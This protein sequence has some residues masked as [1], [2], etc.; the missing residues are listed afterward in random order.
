M[1]ENTFKDRRGKG[2]R[3]HTRR[4]PTTWPTDL[5]NAI[6]N[7]AESVSETL[8]ETSP[9]SGVHTGKDA[10]LFPINS[11]SLSHAVRLI[12]CNYDSTFGIFL[13]LDRKGET[14]RGGDTMRMISGI[15]R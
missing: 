2:G 9:T 13:F 5:V 14:G 11:Y 12:L 8:F 3:C 1:D 7:T 15:N 10:I 6:G 4:Q